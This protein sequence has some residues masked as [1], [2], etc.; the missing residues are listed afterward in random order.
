MDIYS[1]MLENEELTMFI[2]IPA[3]LI[4]VAWL[5]KKFENN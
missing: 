1:W 3:L 2:I 5:M 4:P